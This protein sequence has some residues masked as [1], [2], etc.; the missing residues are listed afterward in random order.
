[1]AACAA[2]AERAGFDVAWLPDSQ[3]LWGE[4]WSTLAVVATRT[5]TIG[6]GPCVINLE[7]RHPSVTAAAAATI[8]QLAPG[9][10]LLGSAAATARS[11]RLG[12]RIAAGAARAGRSIEDLDV[13][14][15]ALCQIA[16]DETE[17]ARAIKPHVIAMAQGGGAEALRAIGVELELPAAIP[18]V[19]RT[20][21]TPRIGR[22]PS[23][24]RS[25][26][27]ATRR[28]CASRVPSAPSAA[29]HNARPASPRRRPPA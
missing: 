10:T 23:R 12:D 9:R 8:E 15:G 20:W 26:G 27:L 29:P 17:A 21:R 4:V 19:T 25:A 1:M 6:L 14:F 24:W 22:A 3:F 11:G 7:T 5:A 2:R 13:C 28:R 18:G 16:G